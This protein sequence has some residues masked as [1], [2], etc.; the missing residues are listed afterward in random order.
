[1]GKFLAQY[2]EAEAERLSSA[3]FGYLKYSWALNGK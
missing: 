2:R 1:V 3:K